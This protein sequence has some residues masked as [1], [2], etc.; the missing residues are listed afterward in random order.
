MVLAPGADV[1]T[2]LLQEETPMGNTVQSL[3]E[4]TRTLP[5]DGS[6]LRPLACNPT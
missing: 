4:E 2:R 6:R 1:R 5:S 3:R